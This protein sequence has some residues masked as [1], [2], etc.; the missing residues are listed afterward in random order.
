MISLVETLF[1]QTDVPSIRQGAARP[2]ML[3]SA[4]H[5]AL[6]RFNASV[7]FSRSH[8]SSIRLP[9]SAGLSGA[10]TAT[11]ISVPALDAPGGPWGCTPVPFR[12]GQTHLDV[13]P[14]YA[15]EMRVILA[16]PNRL[17]LRP[18][19]SGTTTTPSADFSTT[20]REPHSP[21]S[22]LSGNTIQTSR[23]K[24]ASLHPAPA[25]FTALAIDGYGLRDL[26]LTRPASSAS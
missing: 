5:L 22:P 25:G 11:G 7:R 18:S 14:R 12:E 16:S 20:V 24:T 23:G 2:G 10:H 13:L 1:P 4:R 8:T 3:Y 26:M 17:G 21:L 19:L 15:H 9:S 6:T